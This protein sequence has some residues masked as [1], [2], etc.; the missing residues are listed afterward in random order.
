VSILI[1]QQPATTSRGALADLA[2]TGIGLVLLLVLAAGFVVL[3]AWQ[4]TA[5]LVGYRHLEGRRRHVMR[6]GA[7][8]RSITYGYLAVAMGRLLLDRHAA[9]SPRS[10]SA[11]VLA[12]P[13]GRFVLGVAGLVIIGVGVGQIAFGVRR[14]FVDQL[15]DEARTTETRRLPIVVLGQVG[16]VTK[17]LAFAVVGAMVT[18]AAVTD[19]PRKTGGLDQSLEQLVA[20][21]WGVAAVALVGAGIGCFGLYLLA[22]ARHLR[23][24]TLTS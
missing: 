18:W 7:L 12:Q 8:C 6:I 1:G 15:D 10:T 2:Q 9:S 4:V 5:G 11:G 3:A 17:G 22:R 13:L 21:A 14:E 16:Y 20:G 19:D 23:R 24:R